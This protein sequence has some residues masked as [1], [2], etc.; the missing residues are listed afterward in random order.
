MVILVDLWSLLP[1]TVLL[2]PWSHA[3]RWSRTC[4]TKSQSQ[5]VNF[6]ISTTETRTHDLPSEGGHYM[7]IEHKI[8]R[9]AFSFQ[10]FSFF[11]FEQRLPRAATFAPSAGLPPSHSHRPT[12]LHRRSSTAARP[13]RFANAPPPS[14]ATAHI[15]FASAAPP[16]AVSPFSPSHSDD[17][18]LHHEPPPPPQPPTPPSTLR[19]HRLPC[20][21]A[22]AATTSGLALTVDSPTASPLASPPPP[23]ASPPLSASASALTKPNTESPLNS[24]AAALWKNQEEYRKMVRKHYMAGE[25]FDS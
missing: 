22:D 20:E 8:F 18:S 23:T 19:C 1:L 16:S 15:R 13:P 17:T 6:E 10:F 25:A 7:P 14:F 11:F 12:H 4:R 21:D 5:R 2:D 3:G 9:S 24:F